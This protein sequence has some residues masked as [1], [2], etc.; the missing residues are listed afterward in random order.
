MP[1][2]H[3]LGGRDVKEL[4]Y[5]AEL[6]RSYQFKLDC[7]NFVLFYAIEIVTTKKTPIE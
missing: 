1:R 3:K 4:L 7:Y 6:L 2:S 5:V